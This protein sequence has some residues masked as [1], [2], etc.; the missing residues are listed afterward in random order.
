MRSLTVLN[1]TVQLFNADR[2]LDIV[3]T[4]AILSTRHHSATEAMDFSRAKRV[5]K[6][7]GF[8]HQKKKYKMY[9]YIT[10]CQFHLLLNSMALS[11]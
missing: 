10:L 5:R 11:C 4:T 2:S 1:N 9:K 8:T 6:F 3:P 7:V